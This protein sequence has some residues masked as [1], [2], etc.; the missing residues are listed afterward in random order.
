MN[1]Y[2]LGLC[3]VM[4]SY[5]SEAQHFFSQ[6]TFSGITDYEQQ[7]GL[8]DGM[9]TSYQLDLAGLKKYLSKSAL[10]FSN[11]ETIYVSIPDHKG[12]EL[13]Y[14]C[15]DSP[16]MESEI[17]K[18]YPDIKSYRLYQV[19][20]P[21]NNGRI[22]FGSNGMHGAF[23]VNGLSLY[24]DPA[25]INSKDAYVVY[26][27]QKQI[28]SEEVLAKSACGFEPSGEALESP[29]SDF[30]NDELSLSKGANIPKR[31]YR[32]AIATTGEFG[33][34]N[35]GTKESVLS[36]LN[37]SVNRFNMIFE[38]ELM[39]K[40]V[41]V[42]DN[43]KVIFLDP[44]TD[45][46]SVGNN[47]F[48]LLGENNDVLL[49]AIGSNNFDIGHV[50]TR[51]CTDVGGVAAL[52]S[53]CSG[54]KGRAVTCH[55]SNNI[56]ATAVGTAAHELGHQLG[57][58]HSFNHCDGENE[59]NGT[60]FEP[61]S[62]S[63]IMS[64]AGACGNLNVTNTRY[65]HYHVG[66][67]TEMYLLTRVSLGDG[68]G[69]SEDIGNHEP[70]ITLDY[71]DNFS[72][73]IG[74]PFELTGDATDEDGD[75]MTYTWEQYNTGPIS[76]LGEPIGNGPSFRVYA[77]NEIK[78][79]YFPN[80]NNILNNVD[81]RAEVLP[82]ISRDFKF[83]FVVR[84]NHPGG[85][86]AA[87]E[88]M[89][90]R[91]TGSAG[92]FVVT[93]QNDNSVYKVG[94]LIEVTWDVAN[95]D[96]SPVNAEKVNILLSLDG[97][98]TFSDMLCSKTD[99][100]GSEFV[101]IPNTPSSNCR[102]KIKASDNIFFDIN[103]S[104]FFIQESDTAG[105][106][107]DADECKY[108][109]C[110]PE[111]LEIPLTTLGFQGF[112][113]DISFQ[114]I[115]ALPNNI[116][117]SFTNETT[118]ADGGSTSLLLDLTN[119]SERQTLDLEILGTAANMETYSRIIQVDLISNDFESLVT[120]I[121]ENG[122]TG[123]SELPFF[124]WNETPNADSYNIEISTNPA[125]SDNNT[126]T[127]SNIEADSILLTDL[128]EKST[129][130]YW[131]IQG[132]NACGAGPYSEVSAFTTLSLACQLFTAADLPKN[133]SQSGLPTVE[134]R[135]NVSNAGI[136]SDINV[137]KIKGSH[138]DVV[139]LDISLISPQGTE[140]TL[141]K[142]R[143][144]IFTNFDCSFDDEAPQNINCPLTGGKTFIPEQSL[145]A[146][147]GE[148]ANGNWTL[149]IKDTGAGAGGTFTNYSLEVCSSIDLEN[150]FIVK[151]N[152]LEVPTGVIDRITG[153]QLLV[154]DDNNTAEE[155]V[156]TVVKNTSNG[157]LLYEGNSMQVGDTFTQQDIYSAKVKYLHNGNDATE[158]FFLFTVVDG[159]GGWIEITQFDIAIGEDFSSSTLD[160]V[161]VEDFFQVYPN[162]SDG[163]FNIL[164]NANSGSYQ[165]DVL[166]LNGKLIQ[167]KSL[168]N[169]NGKID[170]SGAASQLYLLRIYNSNY[171]QVV[172]I[173]KE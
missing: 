137:D 90:F 127:V 69:T 4:F 165:V 5:V 86:T 105:F 129:T 94:D 78:T 157:D 171:N 163:I 107:V 34:T 167:R 62:G 149:R 131:R 114:L 66:S 142:N 115:T 133:I 51:G 12:N 70:D 158:D 119:L 44:A 8:Y 76:E 73:P 111:V 153:S 72:I 145:G 124:K 100:D 22:D 20:N 39:L 147:L 132:N 103:D 95:T 27:T 110:S 173:F 130:Y 162:P 40:M 169:T 135:I 96:Q 56:E 52:G 43:D 161:E 80:L 140:V 146:F 82:T 10:E 112:S 172:K 14:I 26:D 15:Y 155:L 126:M 168:E 164:Q 122:A 74:T 58:N 57:A 67:L 117:H 87:W 116:T 13:Q 98:Q 63:T 108:Q 104:E 47:G 151:N 118:S 48:S 102:I 109:G 45:P 88:E 9:Y 106:V 50:Y 166:D 159:Q 25:E 154:E 99:N 31:T 21:Q 139:Q 42:N 92:P 23:L 68:C 150:P 24:I 81:S 113:E 79:R 36:Q 35:G 84:D 125:F 54:N 32:I 156:F 89:R 41:L 29:I 2:L 123:K 141:V 143:C 6:N 55:F 7:K 160:G 19:D 3:L 16:C 37:T 61:G 18:R 11:E 71:E 28:V 33:S 136:V 59:N 121:P 144:N 77:P 85:G 128:L 91:A 120:A 134:S 83:R 152:V 17:S 93:S 101:Y 1:K 64:Y 170:L 65:T 148:S 97:G 60:G 49:N 30:D 53:I 46:Y 38:N 138:A 75:D